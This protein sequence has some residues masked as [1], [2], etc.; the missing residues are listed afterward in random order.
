MAPGSFSRSGPTAAVRRASS[1]TSGGTR[2]TAYTA[3]SWNPEWSPDGSRI[4]FTSSR[5]LD[6]TDASNNT[7]TDNIWLVNADGTGLAPLTRVTPVNASC[8]NP[9]WSPDGTRIV[10]DSSRNLDGSD[11]VSPGYASNIWR[12]NADGSGL[13]ALTTSLTYTVST[14]AEWSPDGTRIVFSSFR[15]VDGTDA[16][17]NGRNIWRVNAD[18]SGLTP[19]TT[20]SYSQSFTP[21]WSA[22]EKWIVFESSRKLDG[23]DLTNAN[24]TRNIWRVIVDATGLAPLTKATAADA[25]SYEPQYGP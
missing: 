9:S 18:G 14:D 8:Y 7:S 17:G 12:I 10:F 20:A 23:T 24:E 2:V 19:L 13:T 4:V 3:D 25:S 6:G 11:A 15:K 21:R 1:T 16:P 5:K 22:D